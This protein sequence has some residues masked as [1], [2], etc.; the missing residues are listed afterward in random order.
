MVCLIWLNLPG[1]SEYFDS[2]NTFG[3]NWSKSTNWRNPE[4]ENFEEPYNTPNTPNTPIKLEYKR[5]N[6]IYIWLLNLDLVLII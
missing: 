5:K 3:W 2:E 1:P 6:W 4:F